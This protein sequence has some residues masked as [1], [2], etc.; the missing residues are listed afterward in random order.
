MRYPYIETLLRE[1]PRYAEEEGDCYAVHRD[2]L[3]SAITETHGIPASIAETAVGFCERLLETLSVLNAEYLLRGE[4]CFVSFSAQL[5][6]MSILTALSN[7]DSRFFPADFWKTQDVSADRK[8]RQRDTLKYVEDARV[9][10]HAKGEAMPIR[11]SYVAWGIIKLDRGILFYQRED[12][13]KRGD[14]SAGDYGLIGGRANQTDLPLSDKCASLKALQ[15]ADSGIVKR[16]LP[17][18]LKRELREETG[19]LHG[20]HYN[21][22]PWRV[23]R[24]YR[25]VQGA[26]PYHALTEYHL[27]I[28][29]IVLN[30]DGYLHLC[31]RVK[32]D[33]RLVWF[34]I[35]EMVRGESTDGKVA[36]IKALFDDYAND[37]ER[38]REDLAS[39]PDSFQC[40]FQFKPEKYGMTFTLSHDEPVIAG[41]L[42]KG[43]PLDIR[44]SME[45]HAILLGLAAHVKG[46]E[47]ASSHENIR[48]HPCGWVEIAE[49]MAMQSSL[50][51]LTDTL[52]DT[53][54]IIENHSDTF[55]RLS[56]CPEILF[57]DETLFTISFRQSDLRD[58]RL[59]IPALVT[60]KT[61]D[62]AF[63][64]IEEKSEEFKVTI[65]FAHKL[66]KLRD[67]KFSAENDDAL[68]AEDAYKKGLHKEPRF[69]S[70][71][72]RSLIRRDSGVIGLT[73]PY[74]LL[75]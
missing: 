44:L 41:V 8:D 34:S 29:G 33:E 10:C 59:K 38:L 4:W 32:D 66:I 45:Q 17:E 6:A 35:N 39:I 49:N 74:T 43:K 48:F 60:R 13:R 51:C 68:K 37:R 67:N 75:D 9:Q 73:I 31:R 69:Q 71:G 2:V 16:A 24:P 36:Y 15:S 42:G 26:A 55:F 12:T 3:V 30:L 22:A 54:V 27:E 11:Y 14:R 47:F 18:T 63:G 65:E 64:K 1:L 57:F 62:T 56:V 19:L 25:Q 23:L 58:T 72:L 5:M 28:F 70:L 50:R 20:I 61:L 7:G 40:G 53:D 21:F 52:K 46:F